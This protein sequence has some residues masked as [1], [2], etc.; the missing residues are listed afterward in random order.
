[1]SEDDGLKAMGQVIQ[2]DEARIRDHLGEMVR[3]TVE[4]TLNALLDAEADRL[5][6]AGRYERTQSRQ[7]TRAG[8]YERSLHT[9][10]GEE[11]LKVP[12]LRRQ[13][14]ETAISSVTAGAVRADAFLGAVHPQVPDGMMVMPGTTFAAHSLAASSAL[15]PALPA[16]IL[17]CTSSARLRA[18]ITVPF[19]SSRSSAISSTRSTP[20]FGCRNGF[21]TA[22]A[23]VRIDDLERLPDLIFLPHLVAERDRERTVAQDD[24]RRRGNRARARWSVRRQKRVCERK[25]ES[26]V[27]I[28]G[29][30][31]LA[32]TSLQH[33]RPVRPAGWRCRGLCTHRRRRKPREQHRASSEM[34]V[35]V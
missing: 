3:G 15:T 4:E 34:A 30:H 33:S 8:S 20:G 13:T 2:I 18:P 29:V 19:A 23:L 21:L 12:K 16:S 28:V 22:G 5:C 27:G 31:H 9:V 11:N 14:F 6:G 26:G 32:M 25:R 1:M 7:D 17:L 35:H 24:D 10:A